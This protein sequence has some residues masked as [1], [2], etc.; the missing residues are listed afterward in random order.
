[1]T[2]MPP[3]PPSPFNHFA[4]PL[5]GKA[6]PVHGLI[7]KFKIEIAIAFTVWDSSGHLQ[8]VKVQIDR[9]HC[10]SAARGFP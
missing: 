6:T 3:S 1:M 9:M 8:T 5:P 2:D 4:D 7:A 10:W